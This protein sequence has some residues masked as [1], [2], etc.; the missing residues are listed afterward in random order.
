LGAVVVLGLVDVKSDNRG[1]TILGLQAKR[2]FS[3]GTFPTCDSTSLSSALRNQFE[4][5]PACC[6]AFATRD[7]GLRRERRAQISVND[8]FCFV[9]S[10]TKRFTRR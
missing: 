2:K 10:V 1:G 5:S 3:G 9:T 8:A 6:D 4:A 7:A